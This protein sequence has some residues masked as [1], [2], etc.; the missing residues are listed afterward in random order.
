MNPFAQNR[1]PYEQVRMAF[2]KDGGIELRSWLQTETDQR[3]LSVIVDAMGYKD[4]RTHDLRR[5]WL[6]DFLSRNVLDTETVVRPLVDLAAL[7]GARDILEALDGTD[8]PEY[9]ISRLRTLT[10]QQARERLIT[11]GSMG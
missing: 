9:L 8:A 11:T 10:D 5:R 3:A 4:P 2:E 7:D 1:T 6:L